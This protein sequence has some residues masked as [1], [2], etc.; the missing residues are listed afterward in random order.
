MGRLTA[1][2]RGHAV[3]QT[4]PELAQCPDADPKSADLASAE[5]SF[6]GLS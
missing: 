2:L 6:D 1:L 5:R 4:S 3:P